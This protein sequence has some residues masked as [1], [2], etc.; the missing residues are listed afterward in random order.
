[1]TTYLWVSCDY[2]PVPGVTGRVG[3]LS[4]V[5][6]VGVVLQ[7][8]SVYSRLSNLSEESVEC[9]I[10]ALEHG[11]GSLVFSSGMGAVSAIF[12]GFLRAGDHVV[13]FREY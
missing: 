13:F 8:G 10:N 12:L 7:G 5:Q 6:P 2:L 9:V 1:M 4:A 3:V 11:A